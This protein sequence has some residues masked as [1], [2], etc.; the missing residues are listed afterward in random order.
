MAGAFFR[1]ASYNQL[2]NP[3]SYEYT[4]VL[5]SSKAPIELKSNLSKSPISVLLQKDKIQFY[6]HGYRYQE[7]STSEA[8]Q[9]GI[10]YHYS[11]SMIYELPVSSLRTVE[12]SEKLK[13]FRGFLRDDKKEI[14]PILDPSLY[15]LKIPRS[16]G[17]GYNNLNVFGGND[18]ENEFKVYAHDVLLDF[19]YDFFHTG[20]F[21]SHP[22]YEEL[23]ENMME[24]NI[25]YSIKAK[26][27]YYFRLNQLKN[28]TKPSFL[29]YNEFF[30]LKNLIKEDEGLSS[31]F[32]IGNEVLKKLPSPFE[33]KLKVL[34]RKYRI[35][36]KD[37][38]EEVLSKDDFSKSED[39]LR[40]ELIKLLNKYSELQLS[41]QIGQN[42]EDKEI[43]E[44]FEDKL[45]FAVTDWLNT[46]KE[47]NGKYI[48]EKSFW[49]DDVEKEHNKIY[50]NKTFEYKQLKVYKKYTEKLRKE[51]E[52]SVQWLLKRYNI[53]DATLLQFKFVFSRIE[54]ILI[55]ILFIL[56][57]V[58]LTLFASG[59]NLC[60]YQVSYIPGAHSFRWI[61]K[62]FI[63]ANLVGF[64]LVLGVAFERFLKYIYVVFRWALDYASLK[65]YESDKN[66][67]RVLLSLPKIVNFFKPSIF[68]VS[69]G[70]WTLILVNQILWNISFELNE[71]LQLIILSILIFFT[72]LFLISSFENLVKRNNK[73]QEMLSLLFRSSSVVLIGMLYSF[74]IGFAGM[75]FAMEDTLTKGNPINSYLSNPNVVSKLDTTGKKKLVSD[76][77]K[78]ESNSP[79]FIQYLSNDS[80]IA[81]SLAEMKPEKGGEHKVFSEILP[82]IRYNSYASTEK[83]PFIAIKIERR[84]NK[85]KRELIYEF[86][87]HQ[88]MLVF[89]S[90]IAF[91]IGIFIEIGT[92]REGG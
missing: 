81:D 64:S 18:Q 78:I 85:N 91:C 88:D 75:S 1:L 83:G 36:Q 50:S 77:L 79:Y 26:A 82:H 38:N 27:E 59:F 43:K 33:H 92:K 65:K 69:S 45:S 61:T 2:G 42:E 9:E 34:K 71:G 19:L 56:F 14:D 35:S 86:F 32:N 74:G 5:S 17:E 48:N 87:V 40:S 53:G 8:N 49:F 37:F 72:F 46:I 57:T 21:N 63:G 51:A 30:E 55:A 13:A 4:R 76:V 7:A 52:S 67:S 44:K 89:Y 29:T 62:L 66:P 22:N 3:T 20:V 24:N 41:I 68:L 11:A 54:R 39:D 10:E 70:V 84:E 15:S 28:A 58:A 6:F 60:N 16:T 90:I 31:F 25:L 73:L 47:D 12:L 80:L 23:R